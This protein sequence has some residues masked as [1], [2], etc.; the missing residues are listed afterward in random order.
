M[1]PYP[2]V[3]WKACHLLVELQHKA[4]WAIKHLKF[5]LNITIKK[6]LLQLNEMD[7]FCLQAYE[8]A[9]IY[10]EKTKMRHDKKI[11]SRHF[12]PGQQMLLYN[13]R[14]KVFSGKLKL[15]WL[16]PFTITKV[17]PCG[18]MEENIYSEWE[19]TQALF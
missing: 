10:K 17:Y 7:G 13:S 8:N 3:F 11:F 6:C 1:S 12:E 5:D 19:K 2:L 15:R 9:K 16:G 14:L 18:V 4:Y